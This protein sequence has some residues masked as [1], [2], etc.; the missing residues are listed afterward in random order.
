MFETCE[1]LITPILPYKLHL[2]NVHPTFMDGQITALFM[3]ITSSG[4][5]SVHQD[6]NL[7]NSPATSDGPC[8]P[9]GRVYIPAT[10]S[11]IG[12]EVGVPISHNHRQPKA[13]ETVGNQDPSDDGNYLYVPK[14]V[15]CLNSAAGEMTSSNAPAQTFA[16]SNQNGRNIVF[17]VRPTFLHE[18]HTC[19]LTRLLL[20]VCLF[21]IR[22]SP[23]GP[24]SIT[25]L[26]KAAANLSWKATTSGSLVVFPSRDLTIASSLYATPM[27]RMRLLR[28][29]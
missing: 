4:S 8:A 19:S 21:P 25:R 22:S 12:I 6:T 3:I 27:R 13:E 16:Y 2:R 10:K 26:S 9:S 18:L 23:A 14:V 29:S 15:P 11:C 28:S 7:C 24:R 17:W 20:S 5:V 1:G